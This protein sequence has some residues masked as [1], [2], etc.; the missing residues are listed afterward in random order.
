[1]IG[2]LALAVYLLAL[3]WGRT[4]PEAHTM[5]FSTMALLQLVHSFNARSMEH[6]IFNLGV[7][8]NRS[9]IYAFFAS[10]ALTAAVIFVPFLRGFFDTTLLRA[11]DWAVVI[12]FAL[13]PLVVVELLKLFS[14]NMG[15]KTEGL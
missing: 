4:L 5:A 2:L 9:L 8:S 15:P 10:A 3:S 1:M 14:K 12:G 6:S 11:S 13:I 7:A